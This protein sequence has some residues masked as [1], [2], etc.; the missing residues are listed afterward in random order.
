MSTF[1]EA[2]AN[3]QKVFSSEMWTKVRMRLDDN[4]ASNVVMPLNLVRVAAGEIK[5]THRVIKYRWYL[6][7]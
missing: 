4:L 5:P 2:M 7:K 6:K 1:A 3:T